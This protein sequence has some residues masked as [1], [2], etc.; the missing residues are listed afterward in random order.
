MAQYRCSVKPRLSRGKGASVARAVS[1]ITRSE[2]HDERTGEDYDFSRH[3]NQALFVGIYAPKNAP[4]W[5]HDLQSLTNEIENAEKR[6]DAQLALPLELSLAH[7]LTLEQNRWMLQDFIKENFTRQGYATIAAIHEPP[8]YGDERN[9][10]AHL[11]VTLRTLDENGFSPTKKEQQENFM[12]RSE[13]VEALRHSWEKHLKHHLERHGFEQ[14]AERVSCLSLEAQ[15]IDREA[16]Q[17]L[18]PVA[19]HMER[20]GEESERGTANREIEERNRERERLNAEREEIARA[21]HEEARASARHIWTREEWE[22]WKRDD[23]G[24]LQGEIRLLSDLAPSGEAFAAALEDKGLILA[25]VTAEDVA[26]R[27]EARQAARVAAEGREIPSLKEGSFYVVNA[28][29]QAYALSERTT[30]KSKTEIEKFLGPLDH[31]ALLSLGDARAVMEEVA[32][33]REQERQLREREREARELGA[34]LADNSSAGMVS[35]Q[36]AAMRR[37]KRERRRPKPLH[38]EAHKARTETEQLEQAV[39]S[40][41]SAREV[42]AREE[43]AHQN[44]EAQAARERSAT[45]KRQREAQEKQTQQ[46]R[47]EER[48]ETAKTATR[49]NPTREAFARTEQTDAKRAGQSRLLEILNKTYTPTKSGRENEYDFDRERER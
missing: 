2:M 13:R 3:T 48:R 25:R 16:T 29:G 26:R 19:A 10:H 15:G 8:E 36:Q 11:L 28:Y 41:E 4:E 18:G 38:P 6:K 20:Q 7:E 21:Q 14:E 27:E 49:P 39:P 5:A 45:E 22:A 12:A 42:A 23:L 1:Y 33:Q 32:K 47:E 34:V 9:I 35:Q 30:G 17:H 31:D 40:F 43:E 24:K 46:R 37:I 44:R